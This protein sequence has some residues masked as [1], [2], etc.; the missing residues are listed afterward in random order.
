MVEQ[1]YHSSMCTLKGSDGGECDWIQSKKSVKYTPARKDF[2]PEDH[3]QWE[4]HRLVCKNCQTLEAKDRQA[5]RVGT[6]D[7][8]RGGLKRKAADEN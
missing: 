6:A 3:A 2:S 5:I 4:D 8:A 7:K 1:L